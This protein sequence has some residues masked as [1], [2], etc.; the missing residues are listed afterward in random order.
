MPGI[1]VVSHWLNRTLVGADGATIGRIIEIYLDDR[2]DQPNWALVA[3]VAE[4]GN[5]VPIADAIECDNDI[6]VPFNSHIV[7]SAPGMTPAGAL[8]EEEEADLHR[9]YGLDYVP[10]P[11]EFE[12]RAVR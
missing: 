10:R 5:L 11:M 7:A 2:T 6:S 8:S 1:D 12:P 3:S 9:H 4:R